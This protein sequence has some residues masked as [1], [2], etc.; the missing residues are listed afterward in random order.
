MEIS[1]ALGAQHTQDLSRIGKIEVCLVFTCSVTFVLA[2]AAVAVGRSAEASV[3]P[4]VTCVV[5]PVL[6]WGWYLPGT[7]TSFK[8]IYE[9]IKTKNVGSSTRH[10]TCVIHIFKV[11]VQKD[12]GFLLYCRE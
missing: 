12:K 2:L 9:N 11:S 5:G 10:F 6:I 8:S 1:L 4:E 3:T 7:Y